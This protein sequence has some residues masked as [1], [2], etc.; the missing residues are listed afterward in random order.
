MNL[1]KYHERRELGICTRCGNA[2][3]DPGH[4]T[5]AACRSKNL[6]R[7]KKRQAKFK[8]AGLCVECHRNAK[9]DGRNYCQNC[10]DKASD[11]ANKSYARRTGNYNY[12]GKG[13]SIPEEHAGECSRCTLPAVKDGL[14]ARHL[15]IIVACYEVK[16]NDNRRD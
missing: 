1:K 8:Q 16:S 3:A 6:Q 13:A 11:R 7:Q 15:Q 14:C 12:S 9:K 2:M 10:L 5:C 4:T